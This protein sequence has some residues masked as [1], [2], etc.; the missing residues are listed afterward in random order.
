MIEIIVGYRKPVRWEWKYEY[1]CITLLLEI[2]TRCYNIH[3]NDSS[4]FECP[5]IDST[6]RWVEARDS[7]V[8]EGG[9]R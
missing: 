5:F 1:F 3:V 2:I 4:V 9:M 7:A 6:C 8:F